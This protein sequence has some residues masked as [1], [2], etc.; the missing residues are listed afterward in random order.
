M[1]LSWSGFRYGNGHKLCIF[2]FLKLRKE[3][4]LILSFLAKL[5]KE[6]TS[7]TDIL[8]SFQ[9]ERGRQIFTKRILTILLSWRSGSISHRNWNRTTLNQQK[10]GGLGRFYKQIEKCKTATDTDTLFSTTW[11][12]TE[13][14]M[15]ELKSLSVS[16]LDHLL[17]ILFLCTNL[18]TMEKSTSV[19]HN[20]KYSKIRRNPSSSITNHSWS[21]AYIQH[22]NFFQTRGSLF[23]FWVSSSKT[24]YGRSPL[25]S[26]DRKCIWTENKQAWPHNKLLTNLVSSRR[27]REFWRSFLYGNRCARFVLTRTRANI[28]KAL[29]RG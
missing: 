17:S 9:R 12:L 18:C 23:F 2:S 6:T 26:S 28:P 8:Q 13:R 16:D 27:T 11:K 15:K 24:C 21:L 5:S 4:E 3:S 22:V 10:S 25:N 14:Q 7:E 1:V 29:A 20:L 19:M